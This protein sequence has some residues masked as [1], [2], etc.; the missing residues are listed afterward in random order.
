MSITES[1][2]IEALRGVQ[3]P[4]L[5]KDIVTLDMVKEL[6]L[7][8]DRASLM[9]ELTTP[10]CPL[11]DVIERDIRGALDTIGVGVAELRWGAKV[12]RAASTTAEKLLPGIRNIVA[13]ASGKGG[14]GK[15][16]VSVNL[17]VA[18]AQS[19]ARVG[20]LDADITGPNLP[21]MLG[22]T[23]TPK[24]S[25][26]GKIDPIE[27]HGVKLISIQFFVPEGQPIVWRG[28]LIGG[29]IQ[30]FLRDVEWGELDYLVVDLPP[31]TS[32]AQLTLAQAVP[33]AGTVLVTTPQDV[34]LSDVTKAL[35]MFRRMN[36][37]I[38]GIVENMSAFACPHC[39]DLTEIFGR[40]GAE[41]LAKEE[42][43]ELLGHIPLELAVRQG[44]DAGI[45]TVAQREP[46]PAAQALKEIAGKVAARLA[47]RAVE[48][49]AP[50]LTVA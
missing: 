50:T 13:V 29:A 41:R 48:E 37:P 20:L 6:T 45:P 1:A 44:G 3:E 25:A 24:S 26:G 36:V 17:A 12:R 18:L 27:R 14:V 15:S 35:A 22:A 33:I 32:D 30:Q 5:G 42:G 21:Q 9:I 34:A 19:G 28:P 31:G 11:K 7:D 49:S 46:G 10:A 38:I 47:V 40:G 23:G 4:E 8:G 16:T 43:I 2:V 39:G